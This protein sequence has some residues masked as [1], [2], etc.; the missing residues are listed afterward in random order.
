[1]FSGL[2]AKN[3]IGPKPSGQCF[4]CKVP[5]CVR[6]CRN[7]DSRWSSVIVGNKFL[8]ENLQLLKR[9]NLQKLNL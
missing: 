6:D 5:H 8:L 9:S 4:K 3:A 7:E 1:M 2:M